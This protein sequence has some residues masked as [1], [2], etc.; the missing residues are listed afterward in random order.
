MSGDGERM[1][2]LEAENAALRAEVERLRGQDAAAGESELRAQQAMLRGF[3][4]NTPALMFVKDLEGRLILVNKELERFVGLPR[5]E[6]LGKTNRAFLSTENADKSDEAEKRALAEG[7]A[8]LM[9]IHHRPDGVVYYLNI[10]FP[11]HD[12]NGVVCGVGTVA[13][14]VTSEQ[15]AT[16]ERA[17]READL[18][19]RAQDAM[20]RELASPLLPISEHVVAMPLVGTIDDTRAAQ[21]LDTLLHG[22]THHAARVAILDITGVRIVDTRV[23]HV[24]VQTAQAAKLLGAQVVVTGM[25]AAIAQT[26]VDL[27][28]DLKGVVTLGT[29]RAG[30]AWAI[31]NSLA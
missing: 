16:E 5:E 25:R 29:L 20:I 2:A 30:I 24:L 3:L 18:V 31:R 13:I 27:D 11:V 28:A 15:Q 4:D 12:E 10:K 21:I 1:K 7:R 23:A 8:Q 19:I 17:A 6:I 22:I 9:H 26:L 14:D